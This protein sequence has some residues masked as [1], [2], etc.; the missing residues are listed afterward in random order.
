MKS[1]FFDHPRPRLFAHRGSSAACP[2]NTL[3]AFQAAVQ[4]GIRYLELDVWATRDG[5]VVVHHDRNLRR[6]CGRF[7]RVVNLEFA[8]LRQLD[9]GFGFTPDEGRSH[10][11]RGRGVTVPLLTEVLET[12][13]QTCINIEVKQDKPG[14]EALVVE[15]I[16][17]AD[18]ADRVLL[19]SEHDAVIHRLRQLCGAIPASFSR[20][21]V[22]MFMQ[23]AGTGMA[24]E[25]RPA[26]VA[27]QI[28]EIFEQHRL[29]TPQTLSAAHACGLEVHVWTVNE[30]ADMQRLLAMGVDGV[31]SDRPEMLLQVAAAMGK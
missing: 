30:A 12:F 15:A 19:A 24:G 11:W 8:A 23:W 3:A 31:M 16:R 14:I 6:T 10:P 2:E 4:T 7:R 28:P 27:L 25:Y 9:A 13:P 17:R 22:A 20:G 26:G 1:N 18:A 5:Q 29:V 21:E